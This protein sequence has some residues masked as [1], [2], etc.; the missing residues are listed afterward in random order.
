LDQD[1]DKDLITGGNESKVRVRLGK[2]DANRGFVFVNDG[3]GNF[4]Y[5][6]QY[7]S[8]INADGD[9]RD[10]VC[11]SN[12]AQTVL[13]ISETGEPIQSYD[14]DIKPVLP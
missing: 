3:K 11:I 13:L 14:A 7:A 6:P 4:S 10:I 9:V 8:G 2:T 12:A 1:G 5:V